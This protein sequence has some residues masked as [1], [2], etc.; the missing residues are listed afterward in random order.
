M[1][2]HPTGVLGLALLTLWL[3]SKVRGRRENKIRVRELV[4][5]ALSQLRDQ[6]CPYV[7]VSFLRS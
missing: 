5:T 1:N 4:Q 7:S 6:V 3:R 2:L